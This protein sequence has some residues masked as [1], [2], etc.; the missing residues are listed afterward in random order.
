MP[1]IS[2]WTPRSAPL[3]MFSF[4]LPKYVKQG[5]QFAKDAQK[6]LAYKRDIWPE[7]AVRDFEK[8]IQA[9]EAGCKQRDSQQVEEA[10]KALNAQCVALLP[11]VEDAAWRENCEVF[12]VAIVVALAVRTFFLQ[13]FTIPT[14]SMQ[15]TLN[16]IL[17]HPTTE[18]PPNALMRLWDTAIRGRTWINAVAEDDESIAVVDEV[19]RLFFF[20]YTR[21]DTSKGHTYWIHAP[22]RTLHEAF[23][24]ELHP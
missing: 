4:L 22:L 11:K 15:P 1:L 18:E 20:T 13:P 6:I 10:A 24:R 9:L 5:R 7:D 2:D 3:T 21:V 16:G 12:L 17:G 23:R 8:A 19:S 14:G